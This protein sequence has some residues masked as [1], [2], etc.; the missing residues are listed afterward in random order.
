M[1]LTIIFEDKYGN[2]KF[3][4]RNDET[5]DTFLDRIKAVY[6]ILNQVKV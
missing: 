1:S 2:V 3:S 4:Q 6:T 5:I